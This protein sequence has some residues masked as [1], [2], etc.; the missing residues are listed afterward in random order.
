MIAFKYTKHFELYVDTN[1]A[2]LK[3]ILSFWKMESHLS[4]EPIKESC[5]MNVDI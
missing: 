1:Y 2:K 5:V 4:Y 3:T